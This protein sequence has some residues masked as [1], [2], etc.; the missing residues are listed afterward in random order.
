MIN[1]YEVKSENC[2][3]IEITANDEES[4]IVKYMGM[5]ED[6]CHDCIV[7]TKICT[8]LTGSEDLPSFLDNY[9][10]GK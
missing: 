9:E 7:A 2:D 3:P 1:V 5:V 6:R 8:L 4:A 10:G